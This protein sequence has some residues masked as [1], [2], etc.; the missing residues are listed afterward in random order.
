MAH[1]LVVVAQAVRVQDA[2][3]V[4]HDRVFQRA[5]ARQAHAAQAFHVLH[6]AEGARTRHVVHIG[7]LGEIDRG[8]LHRAVHRRVVEFD[9][10]V[11]L[12]AVV[13][14]QFRPLLAVARAL[15][16]FDFLQHANEFLRRRLVLHARLLQ[17]E[18]EGGSRAVHDRDFFGSDFDV[19]VVDAQARAGRH[20]VFDGGD[21]RIVLDQD[22]GHAGVAHDFGARREFDDGVEV[23][24][25]K[26]DAGIGRGRAQREFDLAARVQPD[27]GRAHQFFDGSLFEHGAIIS[28]LDNRCRTQP[29]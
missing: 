24:A 5:A 11:E 14:L 23:D 8:V 15:A 20:Q 16:H 1:E 3:L 10:E 29:L 25:A 2:V 12:E 22:R 21:A 26:H 28:A 19:Q 13:R 27:A 18:H 17:Q 7:H 9:E 6:E 4:H